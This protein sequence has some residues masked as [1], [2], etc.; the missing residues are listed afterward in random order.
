MTQNRAPS[1]K[2]LASG[3]PP[4]V[5]R[6]QLWVRVIAGVGAVLMGLVLMFPR[7]LNPS[8]VTGTP[9][10]ELPWGLAM[11][12]IAPLLALGAW[13]SKVEVTS[14]RARIVN[15]WGVKSMHAARWW[16]FVPAPGVSS[17]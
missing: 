16:M 17:S 11:L 12:G 10:S 3:Q 14:E 9:A 6:P 13:V 8:W 1:A 5:W 4:R 2:V 7:V 15:P